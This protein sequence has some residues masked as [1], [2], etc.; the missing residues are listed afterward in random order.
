MIN[1]CLLKYL[2]SLGLVTNE[3][4]DEMI[5]SFNNGG[6]SL[7]EKLSQSLFTYFAN[8]SKQSDVLISISSQ[9]TINFL[10][11]IRKSKIHVLKSVVKKRI[12]KQNITLTLIKLKRLR[13]WRV[14]A[15][16]TFSN[17]ASFNNTFP[18]SFLETSRYKKEKEEL[19]ECTFRPTINTNSSTSI[20]RN[21]NCNDK[22]NRNN[23]SVYER[24][25]TDYIR[26]NLMKDMKRRETE[27]QM[28]DNISF[29]PKMFSTPKIYSTKLSQSFSERMETF[30][31]LKKEKS[32]K[33]IETI[34]KGFKD[35]YTFSPILN[36][37]RNFLSQRKALRENAKQ[38][39][40][41]EPQTKTKRNVDMNRIQS[42]YNTYKTKKQ[43]LT[44]IKTEMEHDEGITFQPYFYTASSNIDRKYK[45][46]L[47]D[48]HQRNNMFIRDKNEFINECKESQFDY[49]KSKRLYTSKEKE[50]I[51][52][53]IINRLY[54]NGLQ[55]QLNRNN[56]QQ[57]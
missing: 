48:F 46:K 23:T 53:N 38:N 52:H 16:N 20:K 35:K 57:A 47:A 28:G 41:E 26:M 3:S 7:K 9:I 40:K 56:I 51:T 10:N 27:K 1:E 29:S 22:L 11:F 6:D 30:S 5:K 21:R 54:I 43:K 55:K 4:K 19:K 25:Y 44:N 39:C 18:N 15:M 34:E 31:S 33:R 24:L 49:Q 37:N 36:K 50:E 2:S 42:L 14:I 32:E 13:A 8:I 17:S 12:A 45:S